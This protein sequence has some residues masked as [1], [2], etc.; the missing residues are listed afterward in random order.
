MFC[1]SVW[2]VCVHSWIRVT[3]ARSGAQPGFSEGGGTLKITI[4][5]PQTSPEELFITISATRFRAPWCS[6]RQSRGAGKA[7]DSSLS[8]SLSAMYV[9]IACLFTQRPL[10]FIKGGSITFILFRSAQRGGTCPPCPPP[11][12]LRPW[13]RLCTC[14]S[15]LKNTFL[16]HHSKN[17]N[18]LDFQERWAYVRMISK[19]PYLSRQ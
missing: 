4:N 10:I 15:A 7:T 9:A 2:K 6:V 18:V 3:T 16:F 12:W 8:L 14:K 19:S 17:Q 1:I 5:S 11:P 13:V